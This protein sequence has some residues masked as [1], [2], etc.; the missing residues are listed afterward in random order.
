M[1]RKLFTGIVISYCYKLKP[2]KKSIFV[3]IFVKN[4]IVWLKMLFWPIFH[5]G[6]EFSK[7]VITTLKILLIT[8]L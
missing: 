1:V 6:M 3:T 7:E 5:C 4:A 8:I 2:R